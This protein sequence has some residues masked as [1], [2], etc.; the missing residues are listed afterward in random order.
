VKDIARLG[1]DTSQFVSKKVF[2][3]LKAKFKRA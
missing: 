1:G 2:E 3:R